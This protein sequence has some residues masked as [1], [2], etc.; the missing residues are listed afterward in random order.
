MIE[1][2]TS[3]EHQK[4]V[5]VIHR[6]KPIIIKRLS[7]IICQN[8]N[9][10]FALNFLLLQHLR[11]CS[12]VEPTFQ[13]SGVF[14][15]AFVCQTCKKGFQC[16]VSLQKHHLEVHEAT[17]FYCSLCELT[18][19]TANEAK[20][21]RR[22]HQHKETAKKVRGVLEKPKVCKVCMLVFDAMDGLKQHIF[23]EHPEY[24][25]TCA[26]CGLK[27]AISQVNKII[28]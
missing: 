26:L 3:P 17:Y 13:F 27:F 6:S 15:S 2:L 14:S 18:F 5:A 8:C 1:H 21:H 24:I 9:Q 22:S 11:V 25:S 16:A 20:Q 10:D 19:T 28:V 7:P 4:V 23:R 12:P